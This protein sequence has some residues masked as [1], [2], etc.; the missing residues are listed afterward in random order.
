MGRKARIKPGRILRPLIFC[1]LLCVL[2]IL[3]ARILERKDGPVRTVPFMKEKAGIDVLFLGTSHVMDGIYPLELWDEYGI[4][5]YNLASIQ[6]N[7]AESYWIYKEALRYQKPKVVVLD[8]SR[9]RMRLKTSSDFVKAQLAFDAYPLSE[10]KIAAARDLLDDES[11][12]LMLESGKVTEADADTR[13]ISSFLF[14]LL[15]YHSRWKELTL[16]DFLPEYDTLK[17]SLYAMNVAVPKKYEQIPESRVYGTGIAGYEYIRKLAADCRE[18]GITL[19][20]TYLPFPANEAQQKEAN[21]AALVAEEEGIPFIN[22]LRMDVV[23]Y[24]TDCHDRMSHLNVS[25]AKKVTSYLGKYLADNCGLSDH[26]GDPAYGSWETDYE[27][28][29]AY[30]EE[31]LCAN[32]NLHQYLM[33]LSA[34]PYDIRIE[35]DPAVLSERR[36]SALYDNI[37]SGIELSEGDPG[38][39]RIEVRRPGDGSVVDDVTFTYSM[40]EHKSIEAVRTKGDDAHD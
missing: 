33:L 21:T 36:I 5:S 11:L 19:I 38:T 40:E 14:N 27:A 8:A 15:L 25:G 24:D 1:G 16:N 32:T 29:R 2:V 37:S 10:T 6:S 4:T 18:N 9:S 20:L 35:A 22:F 39:V 17:G 3:A 30:E 31:A 26:R 13:R 28:Y 23:N 12:P 7:T 34:E